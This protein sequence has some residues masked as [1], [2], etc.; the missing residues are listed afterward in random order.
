MSPAFFR[1]SLTAVALAA[2]A[3][4][5]RAQEA[6]SEPRDKRAL[7]TVHFTSLDGVTDLTAYFSRHDGDAP[8]PAVVLMHGC[9]GLLNPQGR[10][11]PLYRAWMR[12]LFAKGYDVRTVD[13]AASRGL[14]Q[15][16]TAGPDRIRM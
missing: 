10:M 2:L 6:A 9:S 4:A 8:R 15:T 7:E 3:P 1:I 5:A 13:S 16:C 14:G 12:V 11:I